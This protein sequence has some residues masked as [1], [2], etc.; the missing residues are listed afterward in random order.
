[1]G[2]EFSLHLPSSD[3]GGLRPVHH[4]DSGTEGMATCDTIAVLSPG[5]WSWLSEEEVMPIVLG[6][7]L[8][9]KDGM[10][11]VLWGS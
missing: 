6:K 11:P 2:T 1:M 3:R 7:I 8:V 5:D 10:F 9:R 4:R